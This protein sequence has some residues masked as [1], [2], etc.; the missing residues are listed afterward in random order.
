MLTRI[1]PTQIDNTHHGHRAALWLLGVFVLLKLVMSTN[2]LLNTRSV[3]TGGDG[4]PLDAMTPD[5]VQVTLMLFALLALGQ[6]ILGLLA[7]LVL[8]R[9]R[10]MVPLMFLILMV[11]QVARRGL[12]MVYAVPRIGGTPVGFYVS[13]G[14]L[15]MIVIGFGLSLVRRE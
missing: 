15:G 5:G 4:I 8:I 7:A 14:L 1:F 3:A 13:T 6:L 2:S 12:I 11:E 9:Y 10:A